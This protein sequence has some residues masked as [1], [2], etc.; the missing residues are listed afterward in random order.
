MN[1]FINFSNK[2]SPTFSLTSNN[3][4]LDFF[5]FRDFPVRDV[6]MG[7]R[8]FPLL[9]FFC[10]RHISADYLS[11]LRDISV[12]NF[13]RACHISVGYLSQIGDISG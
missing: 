13:F 3:P 11:Q 9:N 7:S 12:L 10:A 6:L 2:S 1:V 8:Y 5:R 4:V